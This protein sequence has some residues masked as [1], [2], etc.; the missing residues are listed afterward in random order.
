[1]HTIQQRQKI[2]MRDKLI[3]SSVVLFVA[4]IFYRLITLTAFRRHILINA[5]MAIHYIAR[6]SLC[7]C[8]ISCKLCLD[9]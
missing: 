2:N 9:Q 3:R 5:D 7:I 1:M 6:S 8:S 4:Q